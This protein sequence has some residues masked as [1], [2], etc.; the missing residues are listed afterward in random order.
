LN[1]GDIQLE[2]GHRVRGKVV[3]PNGASIPDGMRVIIS[4]NRAWDR[5]VVPLQQDGGFECR[6]LPTGSYDISPGVRGYQPAQELEN[7]TIDH[8]IDDLKI[9]LAPA[10]HP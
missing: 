7:V 6:G 10:S 2:P 3:L 4:A 5:Q 8:D 9:V 1:V